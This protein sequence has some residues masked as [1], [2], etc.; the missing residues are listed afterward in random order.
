MNG[1][2]IGDTNIT[3]ISGPVSMYYLRPK[4]EIYDNGGADNFPLLQR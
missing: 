3:K 2:Q 1:L 4:Q